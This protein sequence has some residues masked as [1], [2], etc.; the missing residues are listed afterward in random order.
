MFNLKLIIFFIIFIISTLIFGC[1]EESNE[2]FRTSTLYLLDKGKFKKALENLRDCR[3][4]LAEE[5]YLNRGLAYYGLANYN[6]D[7]LGIELYSNYFSDNYQESILTSIFLR[8]EKSNFLELGV[9][10][11]KK[12]IDNNI[13][14]CISKYLYSIPK[15]QKQACLSLNPILLLEN[16]KLD[17]NI[18]IND[19]PAD[20]GEI[21]DIKKRLNLDSKK[22]VSG[23]IYG[24]LN[25]TNLKIIDNSYISI[26]SLALLL[27]VQE[28]GTSSAKIDNFKSEICNFCDRV[29]L[30]DFINFLQRGK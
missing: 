11:F 20:L 9:V 15:L 25:L 5:C 18:E 27:K 16:S 3:G 14:L 6:L 28:S 21:I 19:K 22:L 1:Q 8:T 26:D 10:E 17:L 30:K 13:S 24:D 23:I 7:S 2:K 12:V 29:Q 4:F